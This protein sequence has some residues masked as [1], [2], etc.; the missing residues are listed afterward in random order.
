MG[1]TRAGKSGIQ[2]LG[3]LLGG[4]EVDRIR[5][6]VQ[7]EKTQET[8]PA[9]RVHSAPSTIET[10]LAHSVEDVRARLD[11]AER[12]LRHASQMHHKELDIK[13]ATILS[14]RE[15]VAHLEEAAIAN[16]RKVSR[17]ESEAAHTQEQVRQQAAARQTLESEISVLR[18]DLTAAR[19]R[20]EA[21][22][23]KSMSHAMVTTFVKLVTVDLADILGEQNRLCARGRLTVDAMKGCRDEFIAVRN[24]LEQRVEEAL[25]MARH[26]VEEQELVT[27]LQIVSRMGQLGERLDACREEHAKHYAS[28]IEF[29]AQLQALA[30]RRSRFM[31]SVDI[32][33]RA[34]K[35]SGADLWE[36]SGEN[37][38]PYDTL[39]SLIETVEAFGTVEDLPGG[40]TDHSLKQ[41]ER[42]LLFAGHFKKSEH[43]APE[44]LKTPEPVAKK[45]E[46]VILPGALF[47]DMPRKT[48][49]TERLVLLAVDTLSFTRS[50][51]TRER[52]TTI[53]IK[54]GLLPSG[55]DPKQYV[56]STIG[57]LRTAG[58]LLEQ[59]ETSGFLRACVYT[60]MPR[61]AEHLKT[62]CRS[63]GER[64]EAVRLKL[65]EASRP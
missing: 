26:G 29:Q 43:H 65:R 31:K 2:T 48:E 12:A 23:G 54:T 11:R 7:P 38:S 15:M 44:E 1:K 16:G 53:L 46:V 20:I 5:N 64:E 57:T 42:L 6:A 62:I 59:S 27:F 10:S 19:A 21:L 49:Y 47:S 52:I 50:S 41:Y 36:L 60:V 3:D 63:L 45:A 56:A 61:G 34:A 30:P 8:K 39:V 55:I 18:D 58:Y 25:P 32:L 37:R 35:M 51:L 22:T 13:D 4:Q 24:E 28:R 40:L 14:L 17:L 9:V 33:T